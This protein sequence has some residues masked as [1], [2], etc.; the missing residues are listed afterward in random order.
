MS[1]QVSLTASN[2]SALWQELTNDQQEAIQGGRLDA[3]SKAVVKAQP[4]SHPPGIIIVWTT[5]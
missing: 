4:I 2:Q 3:F 1:E 5:P